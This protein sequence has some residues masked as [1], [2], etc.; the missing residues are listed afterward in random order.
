[1]TPAVAANLVKKGFT[2]NV[3]KGAGAESKF[4]D[5]DFE[6]NGAKLV[7]QVAAYQ[8]GN[9]LHLLAEMFYVLERN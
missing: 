5:T 3:E 8:S 1:M 2:V 6:S 7:D 9:N 4:R